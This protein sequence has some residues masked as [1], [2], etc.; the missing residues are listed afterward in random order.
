MPNQDDSQLPP[1]AAA[2]AGAVLPSLVYQISFK[3]RLMSSSAKQGG[4]VNLSSASGQGR[5]EGG[6]TEVGVLGRRRLDEG[7]LDR[8]C[9]LL[10]FGSRN[11]PAQR[12]RGDEG[13]SEGSR[14]E[15]VN[16]VAHLEFSMSLLLP[17][18]T[19]GTHS[20]PIASSIFSW[21]TWIRSNE[22][23]FVVSYTRT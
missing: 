17:T 1:G 14:K 15:D 18:T 20:A 23:R 21:M 6:R 11:H 8:V 19:Q 22:V 12:G 10:A 13:V 9:E 7:S 5:V 16:R 2:A 4:T 3:S